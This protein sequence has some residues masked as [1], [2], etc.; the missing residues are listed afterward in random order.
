MLKDK[1]IERILLSGSYISEEDATH[2]R[3]YASRRH[4]PFTDYLFKESLITKDLLGQA[5]AESFGVLY[6]DL[7]SHVPSRELVDLLSKANAEKYRVVVFKASGKNITLATDNIDLL[8]QPGKLAQ[9]F[10][11][12]SITIGYSL[13][14]D[15]D[16]V[17]VQYRT[18]L[19]TRFQKII[20]KGQRV[21][22]EIL[23]EIIEDAVT[24]NASDVHFD[25]QEEEVIIRFRIDG[26]L[27]EA[28]RIYQ[29]YYENLL[30]RIKVQAH[31][32]TD[33]H[34]IPQDGAMRYAAENY[35]VDIRVSIVPVVDGEKVVF[36]LLSEY[37]RSF[38]LGAL[39]LSEEG[40]TTIGEA[41]HKPFGMILNAGPTGSGKTTTMY[42]VLKILNSPEVNIAT[43][44][45]PVEYKIGGVNHIQVNR[46]THLTFAQGLRSIVRQDPDIILVGEIRDN[47]TAEIA[48]NAALTGHLMLSTFHANDA[49][50]AIPRLLD[51]G[52]EPFLLASTLELIIAQ[53]LVRTICEQCRVSE[54]RTATEL[55][56]IL[57]E[58]KNYF[59]ADTTFYT[60][61]GCDACGGDGFSGRSAIF[62][63]IQMTPALRE[64]VLGNP[65]TKEVVK[66]ARKDGFATLFEDGVAKVKNGV[67][68]LEELLRVAQPPSV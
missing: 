15:I 50:T 52:I 38:H 43:I 8:T 36:R 7:N 10:P 54:K 53:R 46:D 20:E 47:E 26:V 31:L 13:S 44:E 2:A 62:E 48:V 25:P 58:Y 21:A 22:P 37:V 28:G 51:M 35:A 23:D 32:R 68:T 63:F 19:D 24:F 60:G 49:A 65:S 67:T 34:F 6:T 42:S 12:K 14:E 57:P 45:D 61:A 30:N 29:E 55:K 33:E 3:E 64:L 56:K 41:I 11:Q 9:L 59:D 66:Q 27:Q 40:A 1:D 4:V 17:L 16:A 39:G 18:A 5:I